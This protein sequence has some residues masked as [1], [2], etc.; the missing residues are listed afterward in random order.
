V[1][2]RARVVAGILLLVFGGALLALALIVALGLRHG[3]EPFPA[4]L[5]PVFAQAT[6]AHAPFVGLTE[7]RAMVGG[8]CLRVV[9]ADSEAERQRGLMDRTDLG[10]YQGMLFVSPREVSNVFTM[11]GTKVPLDIAWFRSDGTRGNTAHM[12]PCRGTVS[13]CPLY[14]PGT[15][16]RFALETLR[17]GLPSGDLGACA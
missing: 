13:S 11:S 7:T 4:R 6:A 14:P 17:G 5:R 1:R 12:V 9:I 15:A 10:G 16:W 3:A 8:R 2:S